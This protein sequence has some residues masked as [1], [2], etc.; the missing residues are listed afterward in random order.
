MSENA[1]MLDILKSLQSGQNIMKNDLKE[2]L[3]RLNKLEMAEG[4]SI[5]DSAECKDGLIV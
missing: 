2:I 5:S 3:H 1:L 4:R